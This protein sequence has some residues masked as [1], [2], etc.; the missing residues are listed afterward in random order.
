[1]HINSASIVESALGFKA[2][3][4]SDAVID[5]KAPTTDSTSS[6]SIYSTVV[7]DDVNQDINMV[8]A[9]IP[10]APVLVL[11]PNQHECEWRTTN[12]LEQ[13]LNTY[14]A[15]Y[16]VGDKE[17]WLVNDVYDV[18]KH[19]AHLCEQIQADENLKPG[20][21]SIVAFSHGG[22]LS[23][24]LIEYCSFPLPIRHLVTFGAP[25]NGVSGISNFSRKSWVGSTVNTIVDYMVDFGIMENIFEGTDYWRDPCHHSHYLA[26]SR[27]LAKANNEVEYSDDRKNKWLS[28]SKTLFIQ[29]DNDEVIVPKESAHWAELDG[30]FNVVHR[31]DTDLYKLD[32][33]GLKTMEE[34]GQSEYVNFPGAHM[35]FN[36]TQINDYV[37]PVLRS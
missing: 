30:E 8:A 4:D 24:Y 23:R 21:F 29:W 25:M 16:P 19:G 27:F 9:K 36:Y 13:T 15:C 33:I 3:S 5:I 31:H 12:Y 20:N 34:N 6:N 11:Y 7:T 32:L 22:M 37:L 35:Q 14:T 1:M 26:N 17:L 18:R 2:E 28:L 10:A